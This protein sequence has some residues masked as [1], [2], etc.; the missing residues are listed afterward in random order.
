M[1][2]TD[3]RYAAEMDRFN[4]A[5]RMIG[6][7]ARTGTIRQCTG[8]SEDRIRKIYGTYF[9]NEHG[10]TVRRRRG[11]TPRQIAG[12]LISSRQ[13]SEATVLGCFFIYSGL[14]LVGLEGGL[15]G[16][17]RLNGLQLGERFC[18]AFETYLSL[19]P[20]PQ[21]CFE[22]GWSLYHALAVEQEL[23]FASCAECF[24]LYIQDRY[25]LDYQ[26][27]PFCELK[28]AV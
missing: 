14:M 26:H 10:N 22:R 12:F 2:V 1:R 6:H 16:R 28:A 5:V 19:H 25:A 13:Q 7:E 15:A 3:N 4:L 18:D 23:Y 17:S 24:G 9:K 27:C 8:F 21:L 11:K 20:Q